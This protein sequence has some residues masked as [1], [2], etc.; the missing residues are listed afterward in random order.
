MLKSAWGLVGKIV[1]HKYCRI[2][3]IP[4]VRVNTIRSSQI[5]IRAKILYISLVGG[6]R[7]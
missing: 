3:E 5:A 4:L 6:V 7:T 1:H 2:I